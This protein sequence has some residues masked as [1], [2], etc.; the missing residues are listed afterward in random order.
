VW[1]GKS[2]PQPSLDRAFRFGAI[3]NHRIIVARAF[4]AGTAC[5][6]QPPAKSNLVSRATPK[7]FPR[8]KTSHALL[9]RLGETAATVKLKRCTNCYIAD[10][11]ANRR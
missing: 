5:C 1:N 7:R 2:L 6:L 9:C 10:P 3:P 11:T 8:T 4:L